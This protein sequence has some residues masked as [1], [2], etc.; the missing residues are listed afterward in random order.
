ME[1]DKE[2]A[3]ETIKGENE[4]D[5]RHETGDCNTQLGGEV[6]VD[7]VD[8][9]RGGREL[10]GE[11][12]GEDEDEDEES[13]GDTD[14]YEEGSNCPEEE[15][16]VAESAAGSEIGQ[17]G[18][19]EEL[20][21]AGNYSAPVP[22]ANPAKQKRNAAFKAFRF[23]MK[24]LGVFILVNVVFVLM[25][26]MLQA[27][28]TGYIFLGYIILSAL[29][30]FL[31]GS[32]LA[33]CQP[34]WNTHRTRRKE[35]GAKEWKIEA[36]PGK[37]DAL[38]W[39]NVVKCPTCS[40]ELDIIG[41][42]PLVTA[43]V[44]VHHEDSTGLE[45][46]VASFEEAELPF[47]AQLCQLV[48]IIDGRF[49]G[50]GEFDTVQF[51]TTRFL[52]CRLFHCPE[53]LCI[54]S[55]SHYDSAPFVPSSPGVRHAVLPTMLVDGTAVYRGFLERGIPF[56]V[57][58]KRQNK[59]KRHSHQQFFQ[60]MEASIITQTLNAIMF[61][62]SD[63]V[64]SWKN[65]NQGMRLMYEFLMARPNLGGAC[66]EIEVWK[67]TKNPI[68]ITQYFEYKSNQFLAKT[69]ESWFGMVTCLP[70]AFCMVR[71]C[72]LEDVL[73][74][75]LQVANSILEKNQLA[76]PLDKL[77][78][79]KHV[80]FAAALD[81]VGHSAAAA[82]VARGGAGVEL[83]TADGGADAVLPDGRLRGPASHNSRGG[84]GGIDRVKYAF[85]ASSIIGAGL[86]VLMM[87]YTVQHFDAFVTKYWAELVVVVGWVGM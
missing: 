62:D 61:V 30:K 39:S 57:L 32:L 56:V 86:I 26:Q 29:P 83:H 65:H 74:N 5:N 20:E 35:K 40:E 9:S 49:N 54:T 23:K 72:A 50:R 38:Y 13:A 60:Y 34:R 45:S 82:S 24:L 81:A 11:G 17:E 68:T 48:Y 75:Y 80:A 1:S 36:E 33:K 25:T 15:S 53:S 79:R 43:C 67:W 41:H 19:A 71:P 47:P 2:Q 14:A 10:E 4:G 78:N 76:P 28:Y 6:A 18:G 84:R 27:K 51:D 22:Q 58:L 77:H 12:E 8:E 70:G 66:G 7:V 63:V 87:V 59:G 64:F 52:L 44:T 3:T 42:P 16:E 46:G 85:E 73:N 37:I 69:F 21:A 31:F 55:P